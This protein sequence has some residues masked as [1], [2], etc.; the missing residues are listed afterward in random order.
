MEA[1]ELSFLTT[2]NGDVRGNE[3]TSLVDQR[4]HLNGYFG[5]VPGTLLRRAKLG[6]D[7]IPTVFT[8]SLNYKLS[9]TIDPR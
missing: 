1:V 5:I 2:R 9:I 3:N 4:L 6:S 7:H 8:S